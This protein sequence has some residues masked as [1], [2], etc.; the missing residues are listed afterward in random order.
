MIE[1]SKNSMYHSYR[2]NFDFEFL[3]LINH[4]NLNRVCISASMKRRVIKYAHDNHVYDD[5]YKIINRFKQTTHFFKMR[6]K[7]NC[8]I[9]SCSTCQLLKSIKKS[10][11]KQLHFI[12]IIAKFFIKL[13]INFIVALLMIVYEYNALFTIIDRFF[14]YV[15]FI[16]SREN[17]KASKWVKIYYE[18]VYRHWDLLNRIVF[19]RNLKF[20][21]DFWTML[22]ERSE[23]KLDLIT[24][25][26]SFAN[27]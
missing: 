18:H 6:V 22:F 27:D 25:F 16:S 9:E 11:Y 13:S 17:W 12:K 15:R 19:D 8:Y 4:S 1:D 20:I 7:I 2:L 10:F 23:I 5:F 21:S 26:H 3:Y 24:A 14:K